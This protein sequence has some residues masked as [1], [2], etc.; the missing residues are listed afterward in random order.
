MFNPCCH[1]QELAQPFSFTRLYRHP[2]SLSAYDKGGT[3]KRIG[4]IG[5]GIAGLVPLRGSQK[6]QR[7]IVDKGL[8]R[9]YAMPERVS[10]ISAVRRRM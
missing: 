7:R 1:T 3:R 5:G 9:M 4:I 8:V 10:G 6:S 2:G